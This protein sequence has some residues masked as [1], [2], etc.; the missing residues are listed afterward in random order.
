MTGSI[1]YGGMMHRAMQGLIA[2]VLASVA[3]T[4]LPAGHHF[5]ITFDTRDPD[6]EM[7]DWLR[8]RYP[9]D[10][11]IVLQHWFDALEVTHDRFAVTLNFGNQP[12]RLVVPFDALRSFVDP[13]VEFGLRFET[14][15]EDDEDAD[16]EA[17]QPDV[18]AGHDDDD[19][20]DAP[21]QGTGGGEVVSLD[22]WRK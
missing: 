11:T 14:Q 5:F 6:V 9:E 19:S 15:A 1:D 13:S 2:D 3:E 7:A 17:D 4:G 16:P 10:M 20:A 8:E 21:Q 18:S 12:E 22:K